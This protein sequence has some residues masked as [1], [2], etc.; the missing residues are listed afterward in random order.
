MFDVETVRDLVSESTVG[1]GIPAY[2][3]GDGILPTL[4]T[5]WKGLSRLGL[6]SSPLFL[7]ESYDHTALSSAESASSW[8]RGVGANLEIDSID[9]RRSAKEALNVV[10]ARATSDVLILVDAD[11]L[12]PVQSLLAMIHCLFAKPRPAAVIGATLPDPE[13]SGL[14]HRA[15]AWQMRAV[16]RATSLAPRSITG[17]NS[18]RAESAFCGA[19]RSFYSAYRFPIGSG[20]ISDGVELSRALVNAGHRS[21][22]AAEAFVYK[23]PA[24]SLIDLCSSTV[25]GR[26]SIPEHKRRSN[27]YLAAAIET[28]LDPVGAILY[29]Y[30]R[31]W[32]WR[33]R[34]RLLSVSASEQWHIS[35]TTKR[36][37]G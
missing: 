8:A 5:L 4:Q 35:G 7:S 14:R 6:T 23:I 13:F 34:R 9:R 15:G 20:S 3:E 19:W 28:A 37:T 21:R 30:G 25:R 27:E 1:F 11:V 24:G 36:R 12:I 29:G 26:V 17:P 33:N 18:F 22:N 2:N 32:C 16:T 10:F 31:F